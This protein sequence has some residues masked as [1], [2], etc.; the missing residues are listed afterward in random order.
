MTPRRNLSAQEKS[1]RKDSGFWEYPTEMGADG[2][3]VKPEMCLGCMKQRAWQT[4]KAHIQ[5]ISQTSSIFLLFF[6]I[7]PCNK[8]HMTVRRPSPCVGLQG[9]PTGV[10]QYHLCIEQKPNVASTQSSPV[11]PTLSD[12]SS[13]THLLQ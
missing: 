4:C 2:S 7:C 12:S 11:Q 5:H 8:C 6:L 9:V 1:Q 3:K 10:C 13:G